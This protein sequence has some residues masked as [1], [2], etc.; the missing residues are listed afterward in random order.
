MR[1]KK[2]PLNPQSPWLI[3]NAGARSVRYSYLKELDDKATAE[4]GQ[5]KVNISDTSNE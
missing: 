5:L 2:Y 3:K 1:K 4:R